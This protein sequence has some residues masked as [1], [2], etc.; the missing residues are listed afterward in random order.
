VE[1]IIIFFKHISNQIL[2]TDCGFKYKYATFEGREV[3][4]ECKEPSLRNGLCFFHDKEYLEEKEDLHNK[5]EKLR[6]RLF[7]MINECNSAGQELLCIG[8]YLPSISIDKNFGVI[9]DFTNAVFRGD[10]S[11]YSVKFLKKAYF[12]SVRFLK[13]ASF[14]GVTF[15]AAA[16]F[17][18]AMFAE[19]T[20]FMETHFIKGVYFTNCKFLRTAYFTDAQFAIGTTPEETP[21]YLASENIMFSESQFK[22]VYLNRI[23]FAIEV[24]FSNVRF[25]GKTHF[26]GTEFSREVTFEYALFSK[27]TYFINTKFKERG[28]FKNSRFSNEVYFE[29][30][31]FKGELEFTHTFWEH[32]EKA[33]FDV[34]SLSQISFR[35]TDIRRIKFGE[36]INW[37]SDK[38][39]FK[40]FDEQK[41]E[42]E[43]ATNKIA[44]N[45]QLG[46]IL[47]Q[48]RN[49]RDISFRDSAAIIRKNLIMRN[50]SLTGLYY[51]FSKYGESIVKPTMIGAI[52]VALATLFWL[53]QSKPTLEPH[54]FVS[55]SSSL[56]NST[57]HFVYLNQAG[58]FTHWI[59]AFQRSL[60]DFL[61]L[62]S[63]PG[64]I[65]VGVIDYIIKIVGGAL[66]FGLIII[67]LR[68]KFERKYTR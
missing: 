53:T 3:K 64:D 51:H 15:E 44:I 32:P 57:S 63:L 43:I 60:A 40:I 68:R 50:L 33:N 54:F 17:K 41:I 25:D 65:K 9:A 48:Y 35:N 31:E 37:T 4:F 34:S 24:D 19:N 45:I 1:L 13:R 36:S 52:T 21:K 49:L 20:D 47:S 14:S 16:Y 18:G 59:T 8:Y 7:K 39:K 38:N 30:N 23:R 56:Y 61:P 67:A 12:N 66:T 6:Q 42:G 62:L 27:E 10:V 2:L 22:D 29:S 58:N 5:E 26:G 46:S 55:S 11:F 28:S